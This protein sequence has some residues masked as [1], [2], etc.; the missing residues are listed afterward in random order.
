MAADD[1]LQ[2]CIHQAKTEYP[3]NP[4]LEEVDT[5][6]GR[7]LILNLASIHTSSFAMTHAL[8]DLAHAGAEGPG[9]VSELRSE[10]EDAL[11]R[12]GGEWNKRALADMH[13]LDSLLRESQRINSF[14]TIGVGRTVVAKGGVT[15]PSGVHLP[16]GS[17]IATH[18][19]PVM[20]DPAIYD[21]PRAFKPFR[22]A[23]GRDTSVG[24]GRLAFT[25]TGNEYFAFGAGRHACPGRVF[26]SSVLRL[27]LAC[28]VM[29]YDF[30][31]A[32]QRPKN[33]WFGLH[34]VPD[35]ETTI[36]VT[37]RARH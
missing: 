4:Y 2:W 19:Y 10:I 7:V 32:A 37:R 23:Q 30:S 9:I 29:D 11:T 13:K 20:R 15:T 34:R 16:E 25:T 31:F 27:I 28:I 21:V 6:A 8:L 3:S 35:M 24:K 33:R 22:F 26:A 36:R 18:T 17:K 14:V 5:L 1:F 12:H